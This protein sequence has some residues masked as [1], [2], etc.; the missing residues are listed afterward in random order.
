MRNPVSHSLAIVLIFI[1]FIGC[2]DSNPS[3]VDTTPPEASQLSAYFSGDT[4]KTL[5]NNSF[6]RVGS[7][8]VAPMTPGFDDKGYNI[9]TLDWTQCSD[10]DFYS[11]LL[12]RS[13]T[14]GIEQN[15]GNALLIAA[16]GDVDVISFP[17]NHSYSWGGTYFYAIKTVD[18]ANNSSWS[19][20]VIYSSPNP[21]FPD[22]CSLYVDSVGADWVALSWT[23]AETDRFYYYNC[24]VYDF[25]NLGWIQDQD[26]TFIMVENLMSG[27]DYAA[28]QWVTDLNGRSSASNTVEFTTN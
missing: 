20:E 25:G 9:V 26:S 10:E 17:D 15:T 27:H 2:G 18:E 5:I 13:E 21:A 1:I 8:I 14:A 11:Y 6:A 4:S 12:Y 19:N 7:P 16:I 28:Y 22:P 24:Y 23:R 3:G